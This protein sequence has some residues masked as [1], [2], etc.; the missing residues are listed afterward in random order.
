[1]D[2]RKVLEMAN[3]RVRQLIM[4]AQERAHM[5]LPTPH[6]P[7]NYYDN[8]WSHD[9]N[10]SSECCITSA[11]SSMSI[12]NDN[13]DATDED[14]DVGDPNWDEEKDTQEDHMDVEG[15]GTSSPHHEKKGYDYY[16]KQEEDMMSIH[17]VEGIGPVPGPGHMGCLSLFETCG[18]PRHH[19]RLH[20]TCSPRPRELLELMGCHHCHS[21]FVIHRANPWCPSCGMSLV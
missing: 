16:S 1:M 15:I 17:D 19:H 12:N 11:E 8:G 20:N 6:H 4:R 18:P 13:V 14:E 10:R 7:Y 3:E 21:R 9:N 5:G 2:P